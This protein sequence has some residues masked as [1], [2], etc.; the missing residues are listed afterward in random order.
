MESDYNRRDGYE[1]GPER[2]PRSSSGC[3]PLKA[4]ASALCRHAEHRG[5]QS[6]ATHFAEALITVRGLLQ[7]K[8]TIGVLTEVFA[9]G[10]SEIKCY[11]I[12]GMSLERK[13]EA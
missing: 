3:L 13:L 12:I 2:Y 8:I 9:E 11:I 10:V 6:L 5:V 7:W 4:Q 1:L